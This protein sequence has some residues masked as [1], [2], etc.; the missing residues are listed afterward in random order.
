MPE[1]NV[2]ENA[3]HIILRRQKAHD[4]LHHAAIVAGDVNR[5]LSDDDGG[6]AGEVLYRPYGRAWAVGAN[7][8]RVR[9]RDFDQRL[10]F[11]DYE[12]AV[13]YRAQVTER[14]ATGQMPPASVTPLPAESY[15]LI[16]RW[17]ASGANP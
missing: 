17:Y 14:I 7:L 3:A 10:D 1:S 5:A 9:Q 8:N 11:L 6:V 4:A 12:V 15:E 2:D 16:L 13:G